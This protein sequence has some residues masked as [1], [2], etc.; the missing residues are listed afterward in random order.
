MIKHPLNAVP[1]GELLLVLGGLALLWSVCA[2]AVLWA[3][4]AG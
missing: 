4:F 1:P 2:G 3:I